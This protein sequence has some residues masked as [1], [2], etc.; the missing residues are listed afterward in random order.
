[1]TKFLIILNLTFIV[2]VF[3]WAI[4]SA[5]ISERAI[6]RVAYIGISLAASIGIISYIVPNNS[7][8]YEQVYIYENYVWQRIIFNAALAFKGCADF[9]CQYGTAKWREAFTNSKKKF[10]HI[11]HRI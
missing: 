5:H 2:I 8:V 11:T 1:M 10:L 4:Y 3:L 7:Y 9:Y 6:N